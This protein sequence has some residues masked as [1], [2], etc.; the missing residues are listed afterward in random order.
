MQPDVA[1]GAGGEGL[2]IGKSAVEQVEE[3]TEVAQQGL[4][5]RGRFDAAVVPAQQGGAE[6]GL[7]LGDAAAEGRERQAFALGGA[8]EAALLDRRF[9]DAQGDEV[10][11]QGGPGQ[12]GPRHGALPRCGGAS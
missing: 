7:H 11:A 10:E 4:A 1:A 6:A 12:R 8:R 5:R 9:E 3:R 2:D